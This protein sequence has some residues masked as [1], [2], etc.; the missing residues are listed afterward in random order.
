M[1]FEPEARA[2]NPLRPAIIGSF[3]ETYLLEKSR[4]VQQGHEERNYHVFY[5][6]CSGAT[7]EQREQ[8]GIQD[9]TQFHYLNQS[10][11]Y[12]I[13]GVSDAEHYL[14]VRDA[15][16]NLFME[17]EEQDNIFRIVAGILHLGNVTFN[18]EDPEEVAVHADGE[19]ALAKAAE[20]FNVDKE[21]L[22]KR[23]T[24]KSLKVGMQLI[25]KPVRSEDA[26]YNRDAVS[27]AL[28]SGL[29]DWIVSRINQELFLEEDSSETRWI[30]ILDV[31]GFESSDYD[32]SFEQF[33]INFANERLQQY[34]N[35]HVIQS[36][37]DEYIREALP[38]EELE[39]ADNQDTIDLVRGK[40]NGILNILDSTCVMPKGSDDI[41]ISNLFDAFPKH[42]RVKQA[43]TRPKPK[44]KANAIKA[45]PKAGGA[46]GQ[47]ERFVGFTINH[48]AGQV[49]YNSKGFL[50]KNNDM[51]EGDTITLFDS[52]TNS[53]LQAVLPRPSQTGRKR[54]FRS[55]GGMFDKQLD[56]LM[57]MLR[58][59]TPHFVRCVN[60]NQFKQPRTFDREYFV[61]QLRCGG[62]I[63][64]LRILKLGFPSRVSYNEI[65]SRY[66]HVIPMKLTPRDFTEAMFLAFGLNQKEYQLGLTKVFFRPGKQ[67]FLEEVLKD[68][69]LSPEM[70]T[71]I[72]SLIFKK[73][74]SRVRAGVLLCV[75]LDM[76][77]KKRRLFKRLQNAAGVAVAISNAFSWP[78]AKIKDTRAA[79]SIQAVLRTLQAQAALV[80]KKAAV[81]RVQK[82]VRHSLRKKALIAALANRIQIKE[83]MRN[84]AA[85]SIQGFMRRQHRRKCLT[86]V[87]N[88]RVEATR[89]RKAKMEQ[90]AREKREAE[91]RERLQK[92]EEERIKALAAEEARQKALA[93]KKKQQEEERKRKEAEEAERIKKEEEERLAAEKKAQEDKERQEKEMAA[94]AA[95]AAALAASEAANAEG[96]EE[97]KDID[98]DEDEKLEEEKRRAYAGRHGRRRSVDERWAANQEV[99]ENHK[100]MEA[101]KEAARLAAL[102]EERAKAEALEEKKRRQLEKAKKLK[103]KREA[104]AKA[105]GGK[106]K[107][108]PPSAAPPPTPPPTYI[109]LKYNKFTPEEE[110]EQ[111]RTM[112]LDGGKFLKFGK[113]GNPHVKH[114][115]MSAIGNIHW[116]DKSMDYKEEKPSE[117]FVR[118]LD[119]KEVIPGKTTSV[120][121]RKVADRSPE[122]LCFSIVTKDRTLDLQTVAGE[123]RDMWI[124]AIHLMIDQMKNKGVVNMITGDSTPYVA[125]KKP[126]KKEAVK[127]VDEKIA[128]SSVTQLTGAELLSA[129]EQLMKYGR[130]GKPKAT[131]VNCDEKFFFW[132]KK[133]RPSTSSSSHAVEL[134]DISKV[135]GGKNTAILMRKNASKVPKEHCFSVHAPDRTI[136]FSTVAIERRI[137]W[138]SALED[139]IEAAK[140]QHKAE[141]DKQ[142]AQAD[143]L[144]ARRRQ[145]H[146]PRAQSL[147]VT[148]QSDS[149]L[150]L[151]RKSQELTTELAAFNEHLANE[152]AVKNEQEQDEDDEHVEQLRSEVDAIR[153]ELERVKRELATAPPPARGARSQS[154]IVTS[155]SAP[156]VPL[157]KENAP[158]I[159]EEDEEEEAEEDVD[160]QEKKED[161]DN[162]N[163]AA[164]VGA[165]VAVGAAA[166]VAVAA[167]KNKE[168]E[169]KVDADK[170]DKEKQKE[171]GGAAPGLNFPIKEEEEEEEEGEANKQANEPVANAVLANKIQRRSS[172]ELMAANPHHAHRQADMQAPELDE[173]DEKKADPTANK[174]PGWKPPPPKQPIPTHL[175][176]MYQRR[177]S[178]LQ[179][180]PPSGGAG[181]ARRN[182]VMARPDTMPPMDSDVLRVLEGGQQFKKYGRLGKPKQKFVDYR[183]G[184]LYW[185]SS[186]NPSMTRD[187]QSVVL[188]EVQKIVIGKATD[189]FRRKNAVNT[190][191]LLCFSLEL[192]SRTLDLEAA[193][194]EVRDTWVQCLKAA[195]YHHKMEAHAKMRAQQRQRSLSNSSGGASP[196]RTAR[197][198]SVMAPRSSSNLST[199]SAQSQDTESQD[200]SKSGDE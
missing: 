21:G 144:L 15:M 177:R 158:A 93:E 186:P 156:L 114:V 115:C 1:L 95:A 70:Q 187:S 98:A 86:R 129:G 143:A 154:T 2:K 67:E 16:T 63:E 3:I 123:Q 31:F 90:L 122:H 135:E 8:W 30:G 84:A 121:K 113:R 46:R 179:M 169:S 153:A 78:L 51:S 140:A 14:R 22:R 106:K 26:D 18:K 148:S 199:T 174:P 53:I 172:V 192:N 27:K 146:D 10:G 190:N 97:N 13:K 5:Q 163:T 128:S 105:G 79:S 194:M 139:A 112:L 39:V 142:R 193:S 127:E 145:R 59:T 12:Q 80:K 136:D 41:F 150:R 138:V 47:R 34:F 116:S 173:D 175:R 56:S 120:L 195:I 160:H 91:E 182:T 4:V 200:N 6:L 126:S 73:R 167:S 57:K 66:G 85:T 157:N 74:M 60:P 109:L 36:E 81:V 48:Y 137:A 43:R 11:H 89:E 198:Q 100:M 52:S 58:A 111:M 102:E 65:H 183:E 23:L 49:T 32:N 50:D 130:A 88:E 38:W 83:N 29:F 68:P 28:Y 132:G 134:K 76:W 124:R 197:S 171:S 151:R 64:A 54:A 161:S 178:Q 196:A 42:A 188:A 77:I 92:L 75:R 99:D 87:I 184:R 125:P 162:N 176:E 147:L 24:T 185:G 159:I 141:M 110:L 108:P 61:P 62:L 37:Q 118:I 101:A 19:A 20:L 72:R 35:E 40:P 55:V 181:P 33:C 45:A 71:K 166:T 119:I 69:E 117:S 168:D 104:E 107:A 44:N 131:W 165:G 149:R 17:P 155:S 94:A 133:P 191:P 96:G 103:E 152:Q 9:M 180:Q 82:F 189:V 164:A 7:A 25:A 170:N